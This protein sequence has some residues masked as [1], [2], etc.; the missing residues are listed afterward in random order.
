MHICYD[1]HVYVYIYILPIIV[2]RR[3]HYLGQLDSVHSLIYLS[4]YIIMFYMYICINICIY[5]THHRAVLCV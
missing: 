1:L 5:I 2:L 4:I 3:A